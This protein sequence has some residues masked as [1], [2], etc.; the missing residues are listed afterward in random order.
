[1]AKTGRGR[2]VSAAVRATG[3]TGRKATKNQEWETD[4]SEKWLLLRVGGAD[5]RPRRALGGAGWSLFVG[6]PV[7]EEAQCSMLP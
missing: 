4:S 2:V 1:M 7:L 5:D 6:L 3:S